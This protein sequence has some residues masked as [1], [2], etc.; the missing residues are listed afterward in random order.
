MDNR[1]LCLKSIL[2][3]SCTLLEAGRIYIFS[4]NEKKKMLKLGYNVSEGQSFK[5]FIIY[6]KLYNTVHRDTSKRVNS[7][8]NISGSMYIIERIINLNESTEAFVLV[9]KLTLSEEKY[10]TI[11]SKV[12]GIS[13][14]VRILSTENIVS[15]KYITHFNEIFK[16][17]NI[18]QLM[19]SVELE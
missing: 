8:V 16:L 6:G 11:S 7:V 5:S 13:D 2:V 19:N 17:T 12:V 18:T 4:S 10:S 9:K 3:G 15:R 14:H 1:R